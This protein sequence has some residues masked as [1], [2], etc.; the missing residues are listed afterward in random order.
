MIPVLQRRVCALAAAPRPKGMRK[1]GEGEHA[2]AGVALNGLLADAAQQAQIVFLKSLLA[3]AVAEFAN[4]A[5]VIQPEGRQGLATLK[6]R[7]CA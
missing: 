2:L 7:G 3:A 4:A 1:L 6:A 5:V